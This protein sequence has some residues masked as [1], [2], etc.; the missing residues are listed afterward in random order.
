LTCQDSI[1]LGIF[2]IFIDNFAR[3]LILKRYHRSRFL[4]SRRIILI[5]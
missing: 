3:G 2:L 4:I 1:Y 5:D